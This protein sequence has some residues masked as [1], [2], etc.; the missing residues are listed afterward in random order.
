MCH[1]CHGRARATQSL[2]IPQVQRSKTSTCVSRSNNNHAYSVHDCDSSPTF[3]SSDSLVERNLPL[4]PHWPVENLEWRRSWGSMFYKYTWRRA[5]RI[6]T[7]IRKVRKIASGS[8]AGLAGRMRYFETLKQTV[9]TQRVWDV[10]LKQ[11]RC[12]SIFH[13][14]EAVR[15]FW[16]FC[17]P[18]MCRGSSPPISGRGGP[19]V[20]QAH[21]L[22][23]IQPV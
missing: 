21:V 6:Q 22:S 10:D 4:L 13:D 1:G 5:S 19:V 8:G 18:C 9:G 14:D 3:S 20:S 2:G 7:R 17:V 15:I 23:S 16:G 12:S 11:R